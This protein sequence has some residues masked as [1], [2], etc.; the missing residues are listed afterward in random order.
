MSF[1]YA[2]LVVRRGKVNGTEYS[3]LTK[4]VKKVM[5]TR[6]RKHVQMRLLIRT[7]AINTHAEFTGLFAYKEDGCTVRWYAGSNPTLHQ[8]IINVLLY[9]FQLICRKTV[10]LRSRSCCIF[11][12]QI[13]RVIQWSM[14]GK[15]RCLKNILKLVAKSSKTWVYLFLPLRLILPITWSY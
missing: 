6:Y 8:H 1:F 11:V 13:D 15:S 9:N 2:H 10:L 4:L 3:D 12:Y 14:W 5:D 7:M